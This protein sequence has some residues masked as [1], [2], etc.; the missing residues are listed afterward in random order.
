[1]IKKYITIVLISLI[2]ST[3]IFSA[4]DS[5]NSSSEPNSDGR[6]DTG[7]YSS[8]KDSNLKIG[9]G[10]IKKAKKYEKK[11]KKKKSKKQFNK[12]IKYLALANKEN[13]GQPDILNYLGYSLRKVNDFSMAEIYYLE[14]LEIDPNHIG[15]NEYLGEL[16]VVTNRI[17]LAK[18]RLEVLSSCNC[19]EYSELKVIIAGTKKSKY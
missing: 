16:Y 9:L 11:E 7:Y 3:H 19:V 5:S 8:K 2:Y 14:G 13:P 12:A 6:D 4:E 17:D 10:A 1:M 18:E 15:I